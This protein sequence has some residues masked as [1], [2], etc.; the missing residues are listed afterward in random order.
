[1]LR[2]KT[3]VFNVPDDQIAESLKYCRERQKEADSGQVVPE[4][5][6]ESRREAFVIVPGAGGIHHI[7]ILYIPL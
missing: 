4:V 6:M 2:Q 5:G 7:A 1:M 3:I